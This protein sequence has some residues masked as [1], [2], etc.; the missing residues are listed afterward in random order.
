MLEESVLEEMTCTHLAF[1]KK[2]DSLIYT[3]GLIKSHDAPRKL[4]DFLAS[5][6]HLS[7]SAHW[8]VQTSVA[9]RYSLAGTCHRRDVVLMNHGDGL[10][11]GELWFLA[12]A[13]CL[14]RDA[15]PLQVALASLW[16]LRSV[17]RDAGLVEWI[18]VENPTLCELHDVQGV[19]AYR[20]YA[21]H[22]LTIIPHFLRSR[23]QHM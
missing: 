9:A 11:A 21:D 23:L 17:D 20:R 16:D 22:V 13:S 6:L 5:E 12:S 14:T 8:R 2:D 10:Q 3:I 19:C 4:R 15:D 1:L 7:A 18:P